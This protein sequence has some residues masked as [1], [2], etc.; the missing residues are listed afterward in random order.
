MS[1]PKIIIL[2]CLS[3][4]LA[5]CSDN[6]QTNHSQNFNNKNENISLHSTEKQNAKSDKKNPAIHGKEKVFIKNDGHNNSIV[7]VDE[8]GV[9]TVIEQAP[10]SSKQFITA[11][12][13][14]KGNYI[15]YSS[16]SWNQ[17]NAEMFNIYDIRKKGKLDNITGANVS[18]T[19]KEK[20]IYLCG[21]NNFLGY[22]KVYSTLNLKEVY[23]VHGKNIGHEKMEYNN[24]YRIKSCQYNNQKNE[25]EFNLENTLNP[26]KVKKVSFK[27]KRN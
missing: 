19:P 24:N 15:L 2:S 9:P 21:Q 6:Q 5:G 7:F 1:T 8:T 18:F 16:K 20:Y 26:N 3:I 10:T 4:L 25:I 12:L 23:S 17:E 14:P 13:S 27:I 11:K 22:G